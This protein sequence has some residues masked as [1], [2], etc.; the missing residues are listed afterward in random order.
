LED[1][2]EKL[3]ISGN[4]IDDN[5]FS[6]L[7]SCINQT[8]SLS[9][10]LKSIHFPKNKITTIP[11][12]LFKNLINLTNLCLSDNNI[13]ELIEFFFTGLKS[14]KTLDLDDNLMIKITVI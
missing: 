4:N 9:R 14:R 7:I 2:G 5:K 3:I 11:P 1:A 8:E 13:R 12:H 10:K 6:E